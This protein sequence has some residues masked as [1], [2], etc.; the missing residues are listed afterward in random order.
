MFLGPAL[1]G[2]IGFEFLISLSQNNVAICLVLANLAT[3][4][5]A[6]RYTEYS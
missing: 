2:L 1:V 5:L 4:S 3:G 6:I